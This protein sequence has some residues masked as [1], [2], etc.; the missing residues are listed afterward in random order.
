MGLYKR[1]KVWWIAYTVAAK[2]PDGIEFQDLKRESTGCRK[3]EDAEKV[4]INLKS[5]MFA[6]TYV[7]EEKRS[8]PV[9]RPLSIVIESYLEDRTARGKR[10]DSYRKLGDWVA[11]F[12]D[13]DVREITLEDVE[14]AL[15]TWR[16][17][18]R[19]SPGTYNNALSGIS[20]VFSYA[21]RL[22]W[23]DR[24][25]LRGRVERMETHNERTRWLR[26]AEIDAICTAARDVARKKTPLAPEEW[27]ANVVLAAVGTGLRR[28]N[29]C[30]LRCADVTRDEHDGLFLFVGRDKNG[31][32]IH[33]RL[34]GPL[35]ATV[36]RRIKGRLPAA[37]LFPGPRDGNAYT[38][39]GRF[40]PLA[41]R[42]AGMRNPPF[43]LRWGRKHRDGITFHTTRHS[44]ASLAANNGVPLDVVKRMGNWKTDSMVKRYTHLAD[45]RLHEGEATLARVLH[46]ISQSPKTATAARKPRAAT[47]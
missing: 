34:L 17:E 47:C 22:E 28:G 8:K 1:G 36:E 11:A 4:W 5:A 46:T 21:Y 23:I 9:P 15:S 16:S 18:R 14:T 31:E 6:G 38:S 32:P 24:H 10:S 20:G 29:V 12:G 39:L 44:M 42:L 30:E 26:T 2:T 40:L 25:P 43:R 37:Y 19:W 27:L 7:P 41:V 45:E 33:K 13:R 3:R 35:R